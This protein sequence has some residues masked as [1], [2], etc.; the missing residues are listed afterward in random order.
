MV[1][2]VQANTRQVDERL[3]AS[4]AELLW[5]TDARALKNERRAES[6]AADDDEL[7]GL[8]GTPFLC[9]RCEWLRWHNLYASGAVAFDQNPAMVSPGVMT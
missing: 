3:D 6:A 5:V 8:V 4:L 9:A 2:E 1:L 7:A